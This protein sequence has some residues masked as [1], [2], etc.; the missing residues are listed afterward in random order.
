MFASGKKNRTAVGVLIFS[1]LCLLG[2]AVISK[3]AFP[4]DEKEKGYPDEA[5]RDAL[6]L[7]SEKERD[8]EM[9]EALRR[10]W[11][12]WS[13]SR[14][15]RYSAYQ[16]WYEL[17]QTQRWLEDPDN[18]PPPPPPPGYEMPYPYPPPYPYTYYP[19]WSYGPWYPPIYLFPHRSPNRN[20]GR[21]KRG[22]D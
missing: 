1:L 10:Y 5:G 8:R 21:E 20:I 4:F 6:R 19:P 16:L 18:N 9:A 3:P 2:S 17:E 15:R 7:W 12:Y 22:Q 11:D 13:S 14:Q